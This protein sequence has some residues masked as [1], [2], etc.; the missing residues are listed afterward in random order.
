M[1]FLRTY[2]TF[3]QKQVIFDDHF[4]MTICMMTTMASSFVFGLYVTFLLPDFQMVSILFGVWIGWKIGSELRNPAKL[5][6]LYNGT[7]G[8]IMGTM[9]GAVIQN[10][11][12]CNIPIESETM[13]AGNMYGIA[14]FA[15]CLYTL[16]LIFIQY[17]FRV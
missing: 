8:G 9:L 4:T 16:I 5:N 2:H 12:L 13:I 14:F 1:V 10:P 11:D 15:A 6:G 3:K 17:S 7:M